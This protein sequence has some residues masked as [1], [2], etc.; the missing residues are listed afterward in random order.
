MKICAN[1]YGG[2]ERTP[3]AVMPAPTIVPEK[4]TWNCTAMKP[5]EERPDT[6]VSLAFTL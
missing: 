2:Q 5:P 6:D 3:P 1:N 4:A